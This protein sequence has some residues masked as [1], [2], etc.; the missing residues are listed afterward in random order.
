[1]FTCGI[2]TISDK[3][4]RGQRED[5]TG[6]ALAHYLTEK[7]FTIKYT[8]I[9]PD[10]IDLIQKELIYLCDNLNLNLVITN[11]GTGFSHRDV[12]PEATLN[13]IEK[14]IPGFAEQMRSRS[15]AVT[16]K[17]ALSRATSGIRKN[18]II[19]NLPGSPK[20]ACE[21]LSYIIDALPHGIE[22]LI[23]SAT[24]CAVSE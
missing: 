10:E 16:P 3:G 9:I 6:P 15:L 20:G 21:N 13:V 14:N 4:S 2:V 17:A 7:G 22:I 8:S 18:S 19:V 24:D 5:T 11:G 1:M 23:G 12:T